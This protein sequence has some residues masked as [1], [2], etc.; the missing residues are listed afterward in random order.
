MKSNTLGE[1]E[2][3]YEFARAAANLLGIPAGMRIATPVCALVRN[4][5]Q[6]TD[7]R[8]HNTDAPPGKP[9]KRHEF[10]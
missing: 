10:A 3:H 4:D 6:K 2:T 9:V 8:Q 5:M 7:T 1:S